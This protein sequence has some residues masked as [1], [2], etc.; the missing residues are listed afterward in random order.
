MKNFTNK[1]IVLA[2]GIIILWTPAIM[3]GQNRKS[4]AAVMGIDGQGMMQDAESITY[5]VKLELEKTKIY[6]IMDEYDVIE[7]TK[8]AGID[9]KK[10]YGKTS[11]VAAGKALGADKVITGS[12]RRFGEKIVI[13]LK[14]IDV[15]TDAIEKES[16]KE[17]QNL[18]AELQRMIEISVQ[19]LLGITPNA[20]TV[21]ILVAKDGPI[22]VAHPEVRLDGPR[23]GVSSAL[24]DAGRVLSASKK[25]GGFDMFPANFVFGWQFEKQYLSSGNFSAIFEF[26]PAISGIESGKIIP[27]FTF[28]NGF[29]I[30]KSSWEIAFGPSFRVVKKAQSFQ[31]ADN[32]LGGGTNKWYLENEWSSRYP[33]PNSGVPSNPNEIT[34]HLDSRGSDFLS[35][36]LFIGI[37]RTFKSGYLNIPVNF[38]VLPR[39]EG[40]IIGCSI[41]F[42][43]YKKPKER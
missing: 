41:G 27:S 4:I 36:S 23:M 25:D 11:A 42:N 30:G 20:N 6:T 33:K 14:V 35:T 29:R 24:G 32:I 22:I 18:E 5:T 26:I 9:V 39:K 8:K 16:S 43:I 28:L 37:G 3:N 7:I 17:Y 12:V 31:D 40:S 15:P 21:E 19:T 1:I 2:L 38:Y 10:C 13:S 34:R